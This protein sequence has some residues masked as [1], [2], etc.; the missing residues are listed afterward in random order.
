MLWQPRIGI[1]PS[2]PP[3][4][5]DTELGTW[6]VTPYWPEVED[7]GR[8]DR[9]EKAV[10]ALFQDSE[11]YVKITTPDGRDWAIPI[12]LDFVVARML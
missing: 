4:P 10:V 9:M 2:P 6:S 3:P 5:E 12:H 7:L 11:D 8:M 1:W